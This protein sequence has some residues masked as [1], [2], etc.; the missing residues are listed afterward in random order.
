[1]QSPLLTLPPDQLWSVILINLQG[2]LR[3]RKPRLNVCIMKGFY[4]N[5]RDRINTAIDSVILILNLDCRTNANSYL[6]TASQELN[7]NSKFQQTHAVVHIHLLFSKGPSKQKTN[8]KYHVTQGNS[9][10]TKQ[11]YIFLW[12]IVTQ[13]YVCKKAKVLCVKVDKLNLNIVCPKL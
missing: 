3:G 6:Q 7:K 11:S 13:V 12:V 4:V 10:I 1:M 8:T 2:L 5:N 9:G